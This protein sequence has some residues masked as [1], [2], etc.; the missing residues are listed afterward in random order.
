M[1]YPTHPLPHGTIVRIT[2][3]YGD[4]AEL[5]VQEVNWSIVT[6]WSIVK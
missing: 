2:T 5:P 6:H 4:T 3:T 1:S